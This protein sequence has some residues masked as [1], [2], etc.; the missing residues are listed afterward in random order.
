MGKVLLPKELWSTLIVC[1]PEDAD[2]F[3]SPFLD[4]LAKSVPRERT[5]LACFWFDSE[6][7]IKRQYVEPFEE[8]DIR[9][10]ILVKSVLL[11]GI[12]S[13]RSIRELIT[14]AN[15]QT[16]IVI[17]PVMSFTARESILEEFPSA[18]FVFFEGTDTT[19][20]NVGALLGLESRI[21]PKIV[22]IRQS[23]LWGD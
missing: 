1:N 10:L 13:I 5:H 6:G 8:K 15:P 9:S 18:S 21:L 19:S 20:V 14:K 2:A 7:Y 12:Q 22:D 17:S 11:D 4:S 3:V 16:I 23:L